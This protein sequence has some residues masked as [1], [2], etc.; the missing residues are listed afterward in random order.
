MDLN[1]LQMALDKVYG[2]H[3]DTKQRLAVLQKEGA[4]ARIKALGKNV[5]AYEV[6]AGEIRWRKDG[7]L[8]Q[9]W[10][11]D[12]LGPTGAVEKTIE[13]WQLVPQF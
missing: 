8:E 9:L 13:E 12:C 5:S 7:L 2:R 6:C 10:R 4:T 3:E 1:D 11:I